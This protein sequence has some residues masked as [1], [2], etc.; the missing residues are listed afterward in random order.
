MRALLGDVRR[1]RAAA[2]AHAD[3]LRGRHD[4]GASRA[5]AEEVEQKVEEEEEETEVAQGGLADGDAGA[6]DVRVS[7]QEDVQLFAVQHDVLQE[8]VLENSQGNLVIC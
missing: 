8:E 7:S 3:S 1:Q 6:S 2:A 4:R 5:A